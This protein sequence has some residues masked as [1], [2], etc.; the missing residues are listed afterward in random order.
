[1]TIDYALFDQNTAVSSASASGLLDLVCVHSV[2]VLAS[3]L[4]R[5]CACAAEWRPGWGDAR[6]WLR[7][8]ARV[9]CVI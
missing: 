8:E 6:L 3:E 7:S 2:C 5:G 9:P 4:M 1:M